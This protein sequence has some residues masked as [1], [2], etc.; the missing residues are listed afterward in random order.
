MPMGRR[1]TYWVGVIAIVLATAS[2]GVLLVDI[3]HGTLH[4]NV[5]T[6]ALFVA[7][8][9]VAHAWLYLHLHSQDEGRD[10][11]AS[12]RMGGLKSAREN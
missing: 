2:A 8:G 12:S 3:I 5:L 1:T 6:N 9:C 10:Q 7:T 11:H 4:A